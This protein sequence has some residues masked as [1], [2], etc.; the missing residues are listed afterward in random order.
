MDIH[1]SIENEQGLQLPLLDDQPPAKPPKTASQKVVRKA[2]KGT[3]HL[4]NLLP[5]GSVLT[6]Q[7]LSPVITH[8]GKCKS[9]VSQTTTL[10]LLGLCAVSCFILCFTDSFRDERGKVRYGL[11][12]FRGLWVMD[13]SATL[14]PADAVK[15]RLR[16][17]DFF[18]ALMSILVF[19]AVAMLDNNVIN[20]LYPSPTEEDLEILKALPVAVG[21]VC[22]VFFLLFPTKRHGIGFP[23]SRR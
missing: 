10:G 12:T 6:F 8:E 11:A 9:F 22:S 16:F 14:P 15:F 4:S 19:G 3:A 17:G 21:V 1:P 20:C 5:T 7:V 13:A 23:L 2:F 18:H